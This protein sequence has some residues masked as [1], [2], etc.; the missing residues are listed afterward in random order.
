MAGVEFPAGP[1]MGFFLFITAS[2]PALGHIQP[3]IQW[4][5]GAIT[6]G[7][8]QLR[9]EADNSPSFSAE[10]KN[11]WSHTSTPPLRLHGVVLG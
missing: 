8:K 7:V 2:R 10:V 6:A 4:V 9:R 3:P 1:M 5:P 11:A